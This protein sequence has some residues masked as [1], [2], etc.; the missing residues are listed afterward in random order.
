[1]QGPSVREGRDGGVLKVVDRGGGTVESRDDSR[2][3]MKRLQGKDAWQESLDTL[4]LSRLLILAASSVSLKSPYLLLFILTLISTLAQNSK[5]PPI[6]G[7]QSQK[8]QTQNGSACISASVTE[9]SETL[10]SPASCAT[11]ASIGMRAPGAVSSE[12]RERSSGGSCDAENFE[13]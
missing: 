11:H 9:G 13:I 7:A 4:L 12:G 5:P 3:K 10:P 2:G 1:M 8:A 6:Q